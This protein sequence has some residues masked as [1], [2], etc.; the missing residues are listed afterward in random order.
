M[1]QA[2]FSETYLCKELEL[3]FVNRKITVSWAEGSV[4]KREEEREAREC[5]SLCSSDLPQGEGGAGRKTR[6]GVTPQ[7]PDE[8]DEQFCSF[9][10]LRI[11]K[12]E[13]SVQR[14][15]LL[16]SCPRFNVGFPF[17]YLSISI[18]RPFCSLFLYWGR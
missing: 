5:T 2:L 4:C 17:P 16:K 8:Y 7:I 10:V 3:C 9:H 15:L 14:R 1:T 18:Q 13:F 11:E 12:Q 6:L